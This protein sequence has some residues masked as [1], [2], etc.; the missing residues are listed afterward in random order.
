M[1]C[2]RRV[3]LATGSKLAVCTIAGVPQSIF[4]LLTEQTISVLWIPTVLMELEIL[5]MVADA[6][7]ECG[8]GLAKN[9]DVPPMPSD[10]VQIATV[11][12]DMTISS[13]C[14]R[15]ANLVVWLT[16]EALPKWAARGALAVFGPFLARL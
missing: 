2:L 8:A 14:N 15:A 16:W 10:N 13:V 5:L 11:M 1:W 9:C 12:L 7:D 6:W 3:S 4:A